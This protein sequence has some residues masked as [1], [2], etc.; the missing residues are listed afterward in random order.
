MSGGISLG[1]FASIHREV[2]NELSTAWTK[3]LPEVL[4]D[5]GWE[6]GGSYWHVLGTM[7]HGQDC[8][9]HQLK[10]LRDLQPTGDKP[11]CS[12]SRTIL[13]MMEFGFPLPS[14]HS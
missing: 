7:P 13:N 9:D 4:C 5:G 11:T 8:H 1:P 10:K 2:T 3:H 12:A 14:R 6:A